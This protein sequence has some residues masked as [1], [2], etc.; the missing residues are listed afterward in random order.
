MKLSPKE[1][2]AIQ[3]VAT[4]D[5]EAYD[6]YLRGR[7]FFYE[8]DRK[9]WEF[10]RQMYERAIA[11]DE[12]YALAYA[13]IADSCS[14]LFM[15]AGSAGA[16]RQQA[17]EASSRAL[18]LDP[19]LAEAHAS[20]GL[21]LSLSEDYEGASRHFARAVEL[22]PKL[23]EAYYFHARASASENKLEKAA[24]LYEKAIEVRPEDYQARLL[25]PQVYRGMGRDED[26]VKANQRGI[27]AA[28]KHLELNPGDARALSLGASALVETGQKE[29]GL[30]WAVRAVTIAP[31]ETMLMYNVACLYSLAGEPDRAFDYL[32]RAIQA[33]HA[34]R[35][36]IESDSDLDPIRD[37][38]RFQEILDRMG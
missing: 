14:F 25:L 33:G 13:G 18:E 34:H 12:T 4:R 37:D 17:D 31:H 8:F 38:P 21:V 2:R 28:R 15:Y 24:Q 36:W 29:E 11:L 6:Y 30:E 20:R 22:N 3:N 7:K 5:V 16:D 23:F 32:E 1:R 27:E 35:A 19:E 26:A 9:N 10:A